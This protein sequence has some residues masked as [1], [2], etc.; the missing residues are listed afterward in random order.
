[1]SP[2]GI[3]YVI[4]NS[5]KIHLY[6]LEGEKICEFQTQSYQ[7]INAVTF[8][9]NEIIAFG[10]EDN[11]ISIYNITTGESLSFIEGFENRIKALSVVPKPKELINKYSQLLISLSS[12]RKVNLWDLDHS[13][14][15]PIAEITSVQGRVTCMT[16]TYFDA[17]Q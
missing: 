12:D 1:M 5:Y 17:P 9:E 4:I 6:S 15:T 3:C 7:K 11:R 8:L 16:S 13:S 14:T 2:D 10:G